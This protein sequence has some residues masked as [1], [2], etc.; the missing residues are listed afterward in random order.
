MKVPIATL[1]GNQIFRTSMRLLSWE[2]SLYAISKQ[3]R[4]RFSVGQTNAKS[5]R[6]QLPKLQQQQKVATTTYGRHT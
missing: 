4:Q 6:W 5:F 2:E 3:L 1:L